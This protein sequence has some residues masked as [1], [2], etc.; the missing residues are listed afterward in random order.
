MDSVNI[1]KGYGKVN[2]L[3]DQSSQH[4]N[5][6][7]PSRKP[8][9]FT[10]SI[11]AILLLTLTIG[12]WLGAL[13]HHTE[14]EPPEFPPLSSIRVVCEVTRYP[15]SCFSSISSL[16]LNP[17]PPSPEPADPEAI[18]KLSLRVSIAE[19]S[20]FKPTI[21]NSNEAALRDCRSQ[22]EEA[23]G[24]LNDSLVAMDVGPGEKVLTEAKIGDLKTWISAAM[25]DQETCLDGLEEMESTALQA[26][27]TKMQKAREYTSNS[28]AIL[29]NIHTLLG[30]FHMSLH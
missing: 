8:L 19:L 22:I 16:N 1:F 20:N 23:M 9:I 13:I 29:A 6:T 18:F 28:L 7:T 17:N 4:R 21:S 25:T 27:K 12:V 2:D 26:V 24:Q 11:L 10:F 30:Q 14:T 15:E 5:T 3:E